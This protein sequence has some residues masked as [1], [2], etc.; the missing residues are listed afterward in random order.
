MSQPRLAG[1]AGR[2]ALR[3]PNQMGRI[4]LLALEELLGIHGLNALL[5]FAGL[6]H[7]I[8]HLPPNN[9]EPGFTFH[10]LA[11]IQ[12]GLDDLFGERAGRGLAL[13]SGRASFQYALRELMPFLGIADL[14]FRPLHMGLKVKIGLEVFAETFNRFTDQI[15]RLGDDK[16]HLLWQIERCPVCWGRSSQSPCCHLAVGLLQESL[17][18][19]SNGR[20]FQVSEVECAA[21]G[22]ASCLITIAKKPLN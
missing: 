9:L 8:D 13:L 6:P 3:Y 19:V 10:E 2:D 7:L 16:V 12:Q 5:N 11:T 21:A 4:V 20:R 15:V 1:A 18:W 17:S 22:G 14:A